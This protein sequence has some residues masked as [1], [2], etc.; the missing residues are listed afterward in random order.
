MF[1]RVLPIL[2]L[3]LSIAPSVF[4][5]PVP[6]ESLNRRVTAFVE[7]EYVFNIHL[8]G[9]S[10]AK[11]S[12]FLSQLLGIPDFGRYSRRR[13]RSGQCRLRRSVAQSTAIIFRVADPGISLSPS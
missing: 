3:A 1:S 13:S 8:M 7:Q 6:I 5:A 12:R 9:L 10:I 2:A 4:G 11:Y